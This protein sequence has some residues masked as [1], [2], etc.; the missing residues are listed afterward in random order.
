LCCGHGYFKSFISLNSVGDLKDFNAF[1]AKEL[2]IHPVET[3][4]CDERW[5]PT[6]STLTRLNLFKRAPQTAHILPL[7]VPPLFT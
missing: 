4:P 7:S 5:Q 3:E 1:F 6:F 2:D